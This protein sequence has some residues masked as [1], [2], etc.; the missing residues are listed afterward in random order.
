MQAAPSDTV[1]PGLGQ[2]VC[3]LLR[4]PRE[5]APNSALGGTGMVLEVYVE[6]R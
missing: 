3:K 6:K 1:W 5:G 2:G 4:S